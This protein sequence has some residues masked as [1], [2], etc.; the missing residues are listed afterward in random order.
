MMLHG[1]AI[2]R[3]ASFR[4]AQAADRPHR[5][6]LIRDGCLVY[7]YDGVGTARAVPPVLR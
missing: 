5:I 2:I 3:R 4:R 1:M 6:P 7:A